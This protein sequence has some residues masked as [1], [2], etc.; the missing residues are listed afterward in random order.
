VNQRQY[1]QAHRTPFG[2][3]PLSSYLGYRADTKGAKDIIQGNPLPSQIKDTLP[4]E[5]Q[6][7]FNRLSTLASN[8]FPEVPSVISPDQFK[9]CYKV[10]SENTSS[11]PSSRNLGHYK[12]AVLSDIMAAVHSTM[13][14][15]LLTAGFSPNR[16]RQVVDV[17][18][19]KKAGDHRI[20][21]LH[22]VALQESDFNQSNHIAIGPLLQRLLEQKS[23]APDMQHGSRASK[24]CHSAVLNKQLTFEIHHY[25]KKSISYIEN[26]AIV[27]F[28]RNLGLSSSTVSSLAL[29]GSRRI[30][31]LGPSMEFLH[32]LTVIV[33][34]L[35]SMAYCSQSSMSIVTQHAVISS[36]QNS[37]VVWHFQT[38]STRRESTN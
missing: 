18:L 20:H 29:C 15:I 28:L 35:P 14:S 3:E 38:S 12:A 9:S 4:P 1:H 22:I 10:M 33:P 2:Q 5:T 21:R 17:M 24:L 23:F 36:A 13:M 30:T 25:A 16:W 8:T 6:A 32:K 27:I 26:D 31:V 7:L 34:R 11:S 37:W 19:S